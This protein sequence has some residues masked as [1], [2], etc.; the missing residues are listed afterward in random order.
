MIERVYDD[1]LEVVNPGS[2]H[3]G[4]IPKHVEK[5]V[6]LAKSS[7]ESQIPRKEIGSALMRF[8]EE[9]AKK[10]GFKS[11]YCHARGTAIQFY[12]KN[13]HAFEGELFDEAHPIHTHTVK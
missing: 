9:Y 10:H 11:I 7:I 2:L 13:Q 5:L 3:F 1:H 6:S 4:L 12:Q 8:R